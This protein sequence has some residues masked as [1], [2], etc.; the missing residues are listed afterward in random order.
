MRWSTPLFVSTSLLAIV[1]SGC[2]NGTASDPIPVYEASTPEGGTT[3]MVTPPV[4]DAASEGAVASDGG[5]VDSAKD[6]SVG[7]MTD[8]SVD[9]RGDVTVTSDA[10]AEATSGD[11]ASGSSDAKP[12]ETGVKDTGV[13]KETGVAQDSSVADGAASAGAPVCMMTGTANEGWYTSTGTLIC[14]VT[15]AGLTATCER[16]GTASQGWYTTSGHGC[17][18]LSTEIEK[19]PT[20]Q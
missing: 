9:A 14:T 3:F 2:E 5:V 6:A 10:H 4:R 1:A 20:C 12:L 17:P 11:A 19:D 13:A 7:T 16:V 15:C 8:A 18:P